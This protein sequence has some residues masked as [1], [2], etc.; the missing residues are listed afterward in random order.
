MNSRGK[1]AA[2]P[3]RST[4]GRSVAP[5]RRRQPRCPIVGIGASAGGLEAFTK[6]LEELPPDTGFGFVLVQHLDPQHESALTQ[7]LARVTPMPVCEA[8][9]NLRVRANQ[10]YI[11]PPNTSLGIV[12]GVLKL[13]PR[14]KQRVAAH[15][16]DSFFEAL[17][18][19]RRERAIG[20]ILSGSATD[21][22][23]GLEAIKAEGGLTFAQDESA[24]YDSMPRSAALAGCVD[25]VL[26]PAAIARELARIAKHPY[27]AAG[28][29][30][31][32]PNGV[33]ARLLRSRRLPPARNG[34]AETEPAGDG[35]E[36]IL[37]LLRNHCGVD[38]S[39]YKSSTIHRRIARRLVLSRRATL[40]SYAEFLRGNAKEL[41]ALYADALISV[42]S[43]FRNADAFEVLRRRV[44][45][46]L[47]KRRG[48]EPVR[49]WVLGCSTGQEAYSIAMI[50]A[51]ASAR[52]VRPPKLQIFATD[53]NEANLDKARQGFYARSLLQ[54]VSPRRLR[55]FFAE[56]EGGYRIVKSLRESVVFARQNLISDPPFSRMDLISCRNVMI[57]LEPSLQKRIIPIFHYALNPGG[58]LFLGVSESL[59]SFAHLFVPADR[60]QKIFFR[61]T[62]P[63]V[64][65]PL[66][67]RR[68][69]GRPLAPPLRRL[70]SAG[71]KPGALSDT[72]RQE[73]GAEREADRV[74][75]SANSRRPESWSMPTCKFCN[76]AGRPARIS[77]RP[78]ARRASTCC[79][80]R[81]KA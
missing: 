15:S 53:L 76:F 2:G 13:R 79:G 19:D 62:A 81:G 64:T 28:A 17:A 65:F 73:L 21:G 31:P 51:E 59:G 35:F 5:A 75:V 78:R 11:I 25:F 34:Q 66:P 24:R 40:E 33:Q 58:A 44:L 37:L 71:A 57:Y 38:F 69:R 70:A 49:V 12:Q 20:V 72:I 3:A 50:F 23:L 18:K 10:V 77:S 9:N 4:S 30:A 68:E 63:A 14:P 8:T 6:L 29:P 41:D 26:S 45:A 61:K 16:I 67:I 27:V 47:L 48:R 39:L 36:K 46:A 54:D 32:G 55:R 42:T 56:E 80:W 1:K 7:L 60:K 74:S 52:A 43:F 22:T